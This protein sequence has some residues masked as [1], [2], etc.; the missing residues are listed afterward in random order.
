ML[1]ESA[2]GKRQC[3][4]QVGFAPAKQHI[5][6]RLYQWSV[7]SKGVNQWRRETTF[8]G[9]KKRREDDQSGT[10]QT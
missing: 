10:I 6:K 3:R 2:N 9:G 5:K 4:V 8:L 1:D 7:M